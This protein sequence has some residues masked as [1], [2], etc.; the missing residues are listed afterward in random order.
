MTTFH[1]FWAGY[2]FCAQFTI[3]LWGP[4]HAYHRLTMQ[5]E[6]SKK[7]YTHN[8]LETKSEIQPA[9]SGAPQME[10]IHAVSHSVTVLNGPYICS[11][12]KT[13]PLVNYEKP[14][15]YITFLMSGFEVL[16]CC[17]WLFWRI[18]IYNCVSKSQH[19]GAS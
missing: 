10:R 6:Q 17:I 16:V 4:I 12:T 3:K 1:V 15:N 7:I 2:D 8:M 14:S 19:F 9:F 11:P 13:Q 5:A 18:M